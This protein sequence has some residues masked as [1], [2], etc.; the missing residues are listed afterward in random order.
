MPISAEVNTISVIAITLRY[1]F[2]LLLNAL[3]LWRIVIASDSYRYSLFAAVIASDSYCSELAGQ[4]YHHRWAS[5][6]RNLT[7]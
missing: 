6:T 3:Y 5:L 7:S 2:A 4:C 1:V